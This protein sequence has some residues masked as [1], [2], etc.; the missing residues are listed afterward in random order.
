MSQLYRV[1]SRK[2]IPEGE[3]RSFEVNDK[4]IAIFQ[5]DGRFYAIDD[6]CPHMGASLS[7]GELEGCVVSC[8]LHAWRFDVTNGTWCDNPRVSIDSFPVT[9]NGDDILIAME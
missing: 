4:I 9:V 5:V 7:T 8:P 3:G 2:D 1:A 6:A